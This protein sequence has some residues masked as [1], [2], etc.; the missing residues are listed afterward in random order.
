VTTTVVIDGETRRD[1]RD[2]AGSL[3]IFEG[4]DAGRG[5]LAA[6]AQKI[7]DRFNSRG[8]EAGILRRAVGR[9]RKSAREAASAI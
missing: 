4:R 1:L 8:A 5:D 7:I 6:A 9:P 2:I 3:Q